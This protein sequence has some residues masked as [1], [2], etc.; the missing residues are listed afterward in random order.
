MKK[1]FFL[2]GLVLTISKLPAQ[3]KGIHFEH[4]YSWQSILA[5]AKAENKYIFVDCF[6]TWCGPCKF[7]SSTI[8]PSEN[9]GKFFNEK[10][11]NVKFQLDTTIKDDE[12][13]K[14]QYADAA[15][16]KH[17]YNV[18]AYPT[19]LFLMKKESWFIVQLVQHLMKQN[20]LL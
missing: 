7:M 1:V 15:F 19:Y 6:T 14:K 9:T 3:E 20:L 12:N 16:I 17:N 5:K 4:N 8:F 11:I 18:V 2:L 13:I 10:F